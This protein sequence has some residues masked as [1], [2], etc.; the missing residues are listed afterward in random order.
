[1]VELGLHGIPGKTYEV[2]RYDTYQLAR[3]SRARILRGETRSC[4]PTWDWTAGY[5]PDTTEGVLYVTI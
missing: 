1:M 5:D 3:D 2:K 4:P